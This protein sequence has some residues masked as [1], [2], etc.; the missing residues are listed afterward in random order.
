MTRAAID[1][2]RR[3]ASTL[4]FTVVLL[5]LSP[6]PSRI[7][8]D[9]SSLPPPRP[10]LLSR[11]LI[12]P[13]MSV[14][15]LFEPAYEHVLERVFELS[16]VR[17]M[18]HVA[19]TAVAAHAAWQRYCATV[20]GLDRLTS[21]YFDSHLQFKDLFR[22]TSSVL[23]AT[24]VIFLL[25]RGPP[26]DRPLD[27]LIAYENLA[28]FKSYLVGVEHYE[29]WIENSHR[30]QEYISGNVHRSSTALPV[31][32]SDGMLSEDD[33][34]RR[35]RAVAAVF[36]FHKLSSS[37]ARRLVRIAV[38]TTSVM[39]S[40]LTASTSEGMAF[41]SGSMIVVMYPLA[42]FVRKSSLCFKSMPSSASRRHLL[43]TREPYE[44]VDK[45]D[46]L[47]EEDARAFGIGD[48]GNPSRAVGDSS[49]W[50]ILFS[51]PTSSADGQLF[52]PV[53]DW[54]RRRLMLNR[55]SLAIESEHILVVP[56]R[57]QVHATCADS[58]HPCNLEAPKSNIT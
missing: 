23:L 7:S 36:T 45:L 15:I 5:P 27:I 33:T 41:M 35:E 52:S 58:R 14:Y 17:D 40:V 29:P 4:T 51:E 56:Q 25:R 43:F 9:L 39:K 20:F 24:T 55:W 46:F 48:S 57:V 37:G 22:H 6:T 16:E 3:A 12:T 54:T 19:A 21:K 13:S 28:L 44:I 38:A 32:Q 26:G 34:F 31:V 2:D 1:A 50:T 30:V 18:L 10:P 53:A 47:S 11:C 42:T 49:C 8:S